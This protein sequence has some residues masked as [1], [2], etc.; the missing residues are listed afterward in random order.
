MAKS[1]ELYNTLLVLCFYSCL[2][3]F[4]LFYLNRPIPL[5]LDITNSR[6]RKKPPFLTTS[7]Q[8]AVGQ[9]GLSQRG[10]TDLDYDNNYKHFGGSNGDRTRHLVVANDALFQM[11]YGPVVNILIKCNLIFNYLIN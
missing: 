11:S 7:I 3:S 9:S 2:V 8:A 10:R 1:V 5:C 6:T 4:I